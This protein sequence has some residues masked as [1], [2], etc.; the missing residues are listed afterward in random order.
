MAAHVGF[1][2]P[3]LCQVFKAETGSSI[4]TR[5]NEIRMM[6]AYEMLSSGNYLI[7]Q[8]AM[9]VGIPD[10]FYFNRLFKKK[11]GVAPKT[12]KNIQSDKMD[13]FKKE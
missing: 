8:V 2:E 10:P 1:S 12:V 4:L 11:F 9:E 5:L 3:Y 6:R 13:N 7:K